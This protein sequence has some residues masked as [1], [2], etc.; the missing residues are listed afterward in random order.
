MKILILVLSHND[1]G[2]TYSKFYEAQK[3]TWDSINVDN[4]KTFYIFGDNNIDEIVNQDILTDV[5]E[6]G[7]GSGGYKTL[8]SLELTKHLDFD[9][10]F[11]TNSSSYI[12]K[13]CLLNYLR[14]KPL[15]G[16]YSGFMAEH[17][18]IG[19]ASGAGYFLSRD[20][21]ELIIKNSNLW[22]H[23]LSDDVALSV[24]L[25]KFNILATNMPY[26]CDVESINQ[27]LP[28][29]YFQY[30]FKTGDR[31]EDISNMFYIHKLKTT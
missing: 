28:M 24:L 8:K 1:N 12:D 16:Y 2:G 15:I 4:V 27:Y 30:R 18:Y 11:R 23:D 17:N 21:V 20:L 6:T 25:H 7:V 14:D 22:N 29:E 19:F 26:R 5:V 10:I 13:E 3:K 31:N 9:F